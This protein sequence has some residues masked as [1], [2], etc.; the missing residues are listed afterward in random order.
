MHLFKKKTRVLTYDKENNKLVIKS[1]ICKGIL[2]NC[3]SN[4]KKEVS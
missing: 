3:P 2:R 1:S 4:D